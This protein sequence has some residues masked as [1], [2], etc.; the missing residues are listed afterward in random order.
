MAAMRILVGLV[1]LLAAC[2]KEP[3]FNA[4]KEDT[5]VLAVKAFVSE[6]F[7][8]WRRTHPETACPDGIEDLVPYTRGKGVKDPWGHG[9][10]MYCGAGLPGGLDGKL[11]VV[12]DGPDGKPGTDDDVRSW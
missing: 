10:R 5:A 3:M 6:G 12:S 11:A 4:A 1:L 9:Y 7:P 8:A 2:R